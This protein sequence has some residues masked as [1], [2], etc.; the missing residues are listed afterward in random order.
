MSMGIPGHATPYDDFGLPGE[1]EKEFNK[2]RNFSMSHKDFDSS[3]TDERNR[4]E[5]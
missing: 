1:T 5:E 4:S 2:R 3:D